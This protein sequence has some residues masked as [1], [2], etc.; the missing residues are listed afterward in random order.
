MTSLS[1]MIARRRE[2]DGSALVLALIVVLVVG[3]TVA[4]LLSFAGTGLSVAPKERTLR[5]QTNYVQGAVDGAINRIRTSSFEGVNDPAFPCNDY[6]PTSPV[7]ANAPGAGT[8]V[9]YKV[10]CTPRGTSGLAGLDRPLFAILTLGT[11]SGEGIN[12]KKDAG[13]NL[14]TIDGPIFSN[15]VLTV[16]AGSGNDH[17]VM[18]VKGSAYAKAAAPTNCNTTL[19][20]TIDNNGLAHCSFVDS[21]NI[22]KDPEYQAAIFDQTTLDALI[23]DPNAGADPTPTCPNTP[24]VVE[25]KPGYYSVKPAVLVPAS[26]TGNL[27]HFNPGKYVFDYTDVWDLGS[28]QSVN[29]IG[30]TASGNWTTTGVAPQPGTGCDPSADGVQFEFTGASQMA[31][32]SQGSIELCAPRQAQNFPG[33]P[34]RISL[35]AFQHNAN[36]TAG[37]ATPTTKTFTATAAPTAPGGSVSWTNVQGAQTIGTGDSLLPATATA[38]KGQTASLAYS[39]FENAPKGSDFSKLYVR[40]SQVISRIDDSI[41][42]ATQSTGPGGQDFTI[43]NAGGAGTPCANTTMYCV[44]ITSLLNKPSWRDANSISLTYSATGNNQNVAGTVALDGIELV[45]TY[46]TPTLKDITCTPSSNCT[47]FDSSVNLDVFFRGT[48]YAPSTKFDVEVSNQSGTIFHRGVITRTIDIHVNASSKQDGS[49]FRLPSSSP[50]DRVVLLTG[51]V[52]E[53]SGFQA[54]VQACVSFQDFADTSD[55]PAGYP[56]FKVKVKHWDV[57]AGQPN[58]PSCS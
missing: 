44:D 51:Y 1:R 29:V 31:V 32:T 55:G 7:E 58:V 43:G 2:D 3:I 46:Q 16:A 17:N 14:L 52:D 42:V 19:I 8:G 20:T 56:G 40:I 49:P 26:C 28:P 35:L 25:F 10:T 9:S 34:Q 30:G 36:N 5:N 18:Q 6:V 15:N 41:N 27:W 54:R 33:S 53:G 24:D 50:S 11:A 47:F 45:G 57:N 4:A 13:N 37:S 23:A 48:V 21:N 22:G 39:T 12:Q 38:P